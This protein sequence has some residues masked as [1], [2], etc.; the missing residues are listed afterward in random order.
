MLTSEFIS[1]V[2]FKLNMNTVICHNSRNVCLTL[3]ICY[4]TNY[5]YN[6]VEDEIFYCALNT[7]NRPTFEA[8]TELAR[9]KTASGRG[10]PIPVLTPDAASRSA[11]SIARPMASL[12][13]CPRNCGRGLVIYA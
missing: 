1:S 12:P 5:I 13:L 3:K 9:L 8:P 11:A 10:A 7:S 6:K 4:V 2:Q